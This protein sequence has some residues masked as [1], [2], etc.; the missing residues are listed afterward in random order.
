MTLAALQDEVARNTDV[1]ASAITLIRGLADS[2]E[3]IKNDPE[4]IQSLIDELRTNTDSLGQ[5][6]ATGTPAAPTPPAPTPAPT[7]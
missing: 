4:K 6:V 3:A 5:A 7:P 2:L 1:T